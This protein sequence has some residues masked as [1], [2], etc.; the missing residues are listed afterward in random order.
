MPARYDV[1][2]DFVDDRGRIVLLLLGRKAL[3]FV[4]HYRLLRG[5]VLAFF[6]LGIGVMNSA[7]APRFDDSLGGLPAGIK[8]PMAHAGFRKAN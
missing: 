2:A 8:F 7:F 1:A 5:R 6:G 3:P 4:E